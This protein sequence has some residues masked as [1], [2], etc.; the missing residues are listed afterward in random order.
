[1]NDCAR[2]KPDLERFIEAKDEILKLEAPERK[3]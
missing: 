1:L 3:E 2:A